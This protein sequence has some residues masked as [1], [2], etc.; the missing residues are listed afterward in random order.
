MSVTI[1]ICAPVLEH[2]YQNIH[3]EIPLA[4]YAIEY[5]MTMTKV[6]SLMERCGV[7]GVCA[8]EK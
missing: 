8:Y 1:S 2:L 5:N 6:L 7:S 3:A 4:V